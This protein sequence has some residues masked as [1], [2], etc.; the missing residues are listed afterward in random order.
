MR[1]IILLFLFLILS[2]DNK[3]INLKQRPEMPEIK[4]PQQP[5]YDRYKKIEEEIVETFSIGREPLT[6]KVAKNPFSSSIDEYLASLNERKGDNPLAVPLDQIKLVGVLDASVGKI[7][8]VNVSNQIFFVK[9]GDKMGNAD[10]EIIEITQN[11][12]LVR[13]TRKDI[14]GEYHTSV[15]ELRLKKEEES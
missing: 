13:E 14:F 9:I 12:I 3:L 10:G 5:D 6:F 4:N 8:V 7:G 11:A 1:Y 15:K 2:C